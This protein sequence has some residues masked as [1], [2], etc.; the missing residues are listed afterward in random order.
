MTEAQ[1]L[2]PLGFEVSI[3]NRA[4]DQYSRVFLIPGIGTG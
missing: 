2:P 3:P 1:G 4:N